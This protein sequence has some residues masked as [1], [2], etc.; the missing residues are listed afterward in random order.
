MANVSTQRT[1]RFAPK[2]INYFI[3]TDYGDAVLMKEDGS[4]SPPSFS[5]YAYM[6]EAGKSAVRMTTAYMRAYADSSSA[7]LVQSTNGEIVLDGTIL[8]KQSNYPITVRLYEDSSWT[9]M[10]C[11]PISIKLQKDGERGPQG[12][13][14]DDG[15]KGQSS[16]KSIVFRRYA[17]NPPTPS[18]GSYT[19]PVPNG[20][21][22]GIP[23]EDGNPCWM[24]SRIFTSDGKAPQTNYWATPQKVADTADIVYNFS[25][26][27]TDPGT[28]TSRPSNWHK[29]S[30]VNDIWMAIRKKSNGVW[31][32]WDVSKIKGEKG[33]DGENGEDA[34]VYKIDP[35]EQVINFATSNA[36]NPSSVTFNAKKIVG[37]TM[38]SQSGY[39]NVYDSDGKNIFT[40]TAA[41]SAITLTNQY[42]RGG[43]T[44]PLRVTF[45][46][47]RNGEEK[48]TAQIQRVNDGV[49]GP[50]GDVGAFPI[51][52]GDWNENTEYFWNDT[53][54]CY[55]TMRDTNGM[56]IDGMP[57][58]NAYRLRK[59]NTTSKGENPMQNLGENGKWLKVDISLTEVYIMRAIIDVIAARQGTFDTLV[60]KDCTFRNVL[61]E[62]VI[63]N[64]II[65][66]NQKN[67]S[68]YFTNEN[69][70]DPLTCGS[71]VDFSDYSASSV[72]TI[73]LPCAFWSGSDTVIFAWRVGNTTS[74]MKLEEL[75]QCVGK[76]F[77]FMLKTSPDGNSP[78]RFD[79]R[80]GEQ[81]NGFLLRK[82]VYYSASFTNNADG[83][84]DLNDFTGMRYKRESIQRV[85][86]IQPTNAGNY[87]I[88]DCVMANYNGRECICWEIQDML[89]CLPEPIS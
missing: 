58:R 5:L 38:S 4:V 39:W 59:I 82:N 9:E 85:Y 21:S 24:S 63:N 60:A 51:N 25:S 40:S 42:L 49:Q 17:N 15:E 48:A 69:Y 89:L 31:G 65:H 79:I 22:D 72:I 54:C 81:N 20:W 41:S 87:V 13:K 52:C 3:R 16:F 73:T 46:L 86:Q 37:S 36:I 83:Q 62:G 7:Y 26:V 74:P 33:D 70:F 18:G 6:Q 57:V 71:V 10:L 84:I 23:S 66:I 1:V 61:I 80:C 14:G 29:E 30:T 53:G 77:Y 43:Y 11:N 55:V 68:D 2:N 76:R 78:Q 88:A 45:A 75:R 27:E 28:P 32:S 12:E 44:Y 56:Y 47:A 34:V 19:S 8:K 50:M 64:Q 35:S 67:R